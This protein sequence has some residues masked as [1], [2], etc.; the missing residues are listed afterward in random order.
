MIRTCR[1]SKICRKSVAS[2]LVLYTATY[3]YAGES[4]EGFLAPRENL[5]VEGVPPIPVALADAVYPYTQFRGAALAS[6]HPARREML[7]ATQL[8]DTPQIHQVKFAGGARTQLTFFKEPVWDAS[9]QPT[10]GAYFLFARDKG[11]NE[12]YQKYRFDVASG[13]TTLLTDGRSRNTGGVWS[14]AGDRWVYGPTRRTGQDVDLWMVEP[15]RPQSDKLLAE[16]KG[17][18]WA[19][20]SFSPDDQKLLV[21][22]YVS[23][24]ESY[25]WLLDLSTGAKTEL[26]PKEG[27]VPVAYNAGQFSHDGRGIYVLTDRDSEFQRLAYIDLATKQP[28]YLTK[29][30]NW[31]VSRFRLSWDGKT[32]AYIANEEGRDALHL[33]DVATNKERPLP[34]IPVGSI[35][36]LDWHKNNRDLGFNFLDSR[37]GTDAY[38]LDVEKGKLERWTFSET[39]GV[40]TEK[41][42]PPQ[43]IR[44]KSFDGRMISGWM[45]RPPEKFTG[46]RPVIVQIHG[47][48]EGQAR[49]WLSAGNCYLVN[50]LGVT[51]ILPNVRGS[52]GFGKTFLTLDNGY[53]REDSYRDIETLFD[54]IDKQEDLDAQRVMVTGGSYGGHMTLAISTYYPEQIRCALDIVGMSNLVTFL[55]NTSGYRKDLRRVEYGDERDPKMKEFLN[56]IAPLTNA[57]KITKPLFVV[58]GGNDPRVPLSEAEQIVKTLR[59][60]GTPVWYLMAKDEG[61]GFQKRANEDYLLYATVLFV[62]QYLLD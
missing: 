6:W 47:G 49:P 40:D 5:V 42:P 3:S 54:W 1:S 37:R 43:L 28:T 53:K 8:A 31:D 32:I 9:F 21:L 13:E 29:D 50:E 20:I 33:L 36:G 24:N 51:L 18:G 55:E 16:L 52:I 48:P 60:Q 23:V 27:D 61:H 19:A 41:I 57:D 10:E 22:N 14:N 39:G 46:K 7:I 59:Q 15:A 45:F 2:L 25:L 12:N 17:G 11:G 4:E 58:Q 35:G 56:R 26:T 44:W 62:Q 34:E 38:A 30:L